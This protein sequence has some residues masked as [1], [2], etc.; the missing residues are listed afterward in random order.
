MNYK[1]THNY[2]GGPDVGYISKPHKVQPE[3]DE[4]CHYYN[5]NWFDPKL[6]PEF[7][8]KVREPIFITED[9]VSINCGDTY[10]YVWF[11]GDVESIQQKLYT[12]YSFVARES[13]GSFIDSKTFSTKDKAEAWIEEN[14]PQ[15]SKL[16]MMSFS[17]YSKGMSCHSN[18]TE[19]FDRWLKSPYN[20]KK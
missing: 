2:P 16:D 13:P 5:H 9:G 18:S 12:A 1:C 4:N 19:D 14:K 15:Y 3:T 17:C 20:T 11:S 8:E 7:W 6:Y 10:W